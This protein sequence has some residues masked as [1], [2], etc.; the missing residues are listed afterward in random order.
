[1]QARYWQHIVK[2][3]R[4][5][6]AFDLGDEFCNPNQTNKPIWQWR[7]V[8]L[9]LPSIAVSYLVFK[10][11]NFSD[12]PWPNRNF[13]QIERL[14]SEARI[15]TEYLYNLYIPQIELKGLYQDGYNIS[16]GLLQ[17]ISTLVNIIFDGLITERFYCT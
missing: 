4:T 16:K 14:F 2:K 11:I 9:W 1:M 8:C 17:P 6:T 13:N 12:N 15:V 5:I 10:N 7:A 3:W